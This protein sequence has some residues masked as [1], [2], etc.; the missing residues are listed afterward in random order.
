ME[1]KTLDSL[2]QEE[3]DQKFENFYLSQKRY[4]F[5]LK[6]QN[7]QFECQPGH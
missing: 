7:W 6:S 3:E 2:K 4:F 1:S 5:F